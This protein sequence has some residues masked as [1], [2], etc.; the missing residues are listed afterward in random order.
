MFSKFFEKGI[1]KTF[2]QLAEKPPLKF[3]FKSIDFGG[4]VNHSVSF[5]CT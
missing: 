1:P 2:Q 3:V 5:L 4:A